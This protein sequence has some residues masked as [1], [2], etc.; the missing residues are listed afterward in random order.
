MNRDRRIKQGG[1]RATRAATR[2]TDPT[3]NHAPTTL[4]VI[5]V[6]VA[7]SVS[8]LLGLSQAAVSA[9]TSHGDRALTSV[10]VTA[11]QVEFTGALTSFARL[12]GLAEGS[13]SDLEPSDLEPVPT[14]I[15]DSG[16]TATHSAS[17]TVTTIPDRENS[18]A[19]EAAGT[20]TTAVDTSTTAPPTTSGEPS[21]TSVPTVQ[22]DNARMAV[23]PWKPISA[24]DF[25]RYVDE[26]HLS[27]VE[28]VTPGLVHG[29]IVSDDQRINIVLVHRSA[30]APMRV[31]PAGRGPE[32]V[33]A[34]AREI[35]ATAGVNGNWYEPFDGPAVSDG[36]A[37]GGADHGYTA[38]FGFTHDGDLVADHHHKLHE[39]VDPRI[40]EAVSGHP[41]LI[42][43]GS[44]TTD[45]GNDP[46]F[47]TRHPR[48]VIGVTATVD[49]LILVTVDGRSSDA[50]GMTGA[51]TTRL[52]TRL[53]AFD[54]VMLDGGGSSA[55]WIAGK[56]IV[57]RPADPGR[58]VG[59]QIAVFGR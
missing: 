13:T 46:T 9:T 56:G 6:T 21:T 53:G 29:T 12:P 51:E 55:M 28:Y 33:G 10:A 43:R 40:A 52:M 17:S 22:T 23:R 49:V 39:T 44:A 8:A 25:R 42:H 11:D 38:V 54:A 59:N 2:A 45:F 58:A 3:P 31:S 50:T 37:Y 27:T 47:V 20:A 19:G 1:V 57:N 15:S 48:T 14:T 30:T 16:R 26:R 7:V 34:W 24:A 41:T 32:P 5:I 18:T 35:G 36:Q 4:S